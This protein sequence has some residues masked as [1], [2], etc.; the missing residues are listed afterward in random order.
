M[1]LPEDRALDNVWMNGT[2][3]GMNKENIMNYKT[4][5]KLKKEKVTR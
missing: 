1:V 4:E 3:I 5:R 2:I